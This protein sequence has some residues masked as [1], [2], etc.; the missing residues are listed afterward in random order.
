MAGGVVRGGGGE[1]R[2]GGGLH[3]SQR[4]QVGKQ[5]GAVPVA[6]GPRMRIAVQIDRLIVIEPLRAAIEVHAMLAGWDHPEWDPGELEA[7]QRTLTANAAR[8]L[9]AVDQ[10]LNYIHQ[11]T[12]QRLTLEA[13][14]TAHATGTG[15]GGVK[16][17]VPLPPD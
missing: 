4:T 9:P 14:R 6:A 8:L 17:T 13:I 5:D 11:R 3:G 10:V 1:G 12:V 2:T 7:M 16:E 15:V